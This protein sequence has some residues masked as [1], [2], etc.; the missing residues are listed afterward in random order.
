MKIRGWLTMAAVA[1][2][3]SGTLITVPMRHCVAVVLK[4]GVRGVGWS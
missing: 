2:L 4:F 1:G 3:A